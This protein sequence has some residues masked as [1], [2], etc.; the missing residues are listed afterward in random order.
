M[1]QFIAKRIL[2]TIPVL[3]GVTLIT[4][5]LVNV[6][7]GD[8]ITAMMEKRADPATVAKLRHEYGLDAPLYLQYLRFLGHAVEG[9]LGKSFRTKQPVTQAIR[10]HFPATV[11]LAVS[12]MLVALILGLAVGII[13]A[14]KQ[15]SW[16][17]HGSM[18]VALA[19]IS[20]P[21]FWVAIMLQ[22]LFGMYWKILPISGYTGWRSMVLPAVALGSRYAASIA[23]LTRSSLLETTRQDYVRT[24]RAKG[25]DERVVIFKHALKNAIIPVVTVIGLQ[26]GGL[27]TGAILTES[28]FGIPGLGRLAI[29]AINHRDF[30]LI[31]G[32]V[33]FTAVIYVLSNL[34]VD[35]SY[36]YLDPRI[37]LE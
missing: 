29:D 6:V 14:V 8:P 31:Q 9:D 36:A 35:I 7:P 18:I 10:E 34:V 17:D 33:L 1:L 24:A 3:V 23:R 21:I 5:I 19:G 13:S 25:L 37:R 27:L 30:P 15:Y 11:K 26:I 2:A 22:I 4:F 28:V 12:S 32:T 20:A 16:F